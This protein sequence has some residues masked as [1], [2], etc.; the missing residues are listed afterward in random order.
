[1]KWI[2]V[3]RVTDEVK[4]WLVE[5]YN[6]YEVA[7]GLVAIG[8]TL[9]TVQEAMITFNMKEDKILFQYYNFTKGRWEKWHYV[10]HFCLFKDIPLPKGDNDG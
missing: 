5:N 7:N 4:K 6:P 9:P 8:E 10:S 1:M 2:H 3:D